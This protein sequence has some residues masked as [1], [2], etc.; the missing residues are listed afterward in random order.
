MQLPDCV[1]EPAGVLGTFSD[2][3][4]SW[5]FESCLPNGECL[6]LLSP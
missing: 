2:S 1:G 5:G 4:I 6:D 3:I